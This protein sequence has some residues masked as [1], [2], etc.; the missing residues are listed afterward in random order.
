MSESEA[1][2]AYEIMS[3]STQNGQAAKPPQATVSAFSVPAA[4]GAQGPAEFH[5]PIEQPFSAFGSISQ[6]KEA[7][8]MATMLAH[9]SIVPETYRGMRTSATV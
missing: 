8:R 2:T 3:T 4:N 1:K 7:Q 9:S 5:Q 6:F